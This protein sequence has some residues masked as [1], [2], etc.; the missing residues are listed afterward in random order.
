MNALGDLLTRYAQRYGD[1][2]AVSAG[3]D[4]A[5]S[6]AEL[7]PASRHAEAW[8]HEVVP[9]SP[10][11]LLP[12]NTPGDVALLLGALRS[13]LV[14]LVGDPAWSEHEIAE[15]L[16]RTGASSV[17]RAQ[18][19]ESVAASITL[20]DGGV[21]Y[22]ELAAE[23]G[24]PLRH[25]L[26]GIDF[27]RFTSGSSGAPRCLGFGIEAMINAASAWGAATQ[28]TSADTVMCLAALNNGLAFN[29]SLLAVFE[30]GATLVLPGVRPIPSSMLAALRTW[31]PTVLVA[32]PFVY[33]ALAERDLGGLT[34][35][36]LL[37]SSAAPLRPDTDRRWSAELGTHICNYYG[38]A[39]VGP[40]TFNDGRVAGSL[41]RA[42]AGVELLEIPT[43]E[44]ENGS[45]A[46]D[47]TP[48]RIAV[49]TAAMATRYLDPRPPDFA[50]HLDS[51]G[52][53]LTQD[54]GFLR[55]GDLFIT[56]RAD[57]IVNIAGRKIDPGEIADVLLRHHDVSG[58]LVR[59]EPT[60]T[61]PVLCAYVESATAG[62]SDLI[63][64][65]RKY[66]SQYKIPQRWTIVPALPRSSAGKIMSAQLAGIGGASQ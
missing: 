45:R 16:K 46:V 60:T 56:G 2:T 66:L 29:T 42:L 15:T 30:V 18:R 9:H 43:P 7:E 65:C 10:F 53:Y 41:G 12:G 36:R 62:R 35:L 64:H 38:L 31:S 25:D 13:G 34:S 59:A 51:N 50:D 1:R 27:G 5:Y 22:L 32:F 20:G 17:V 28:L 24:A 23:P 33:E 21:R 11:L 57:R 48:A 39:E 52:R 40:V 54:L 37:V 49:R 47:P 44:T 58:A 55:D 6:Y 63:D 61:E 8:L 14:P 3:A 4:A 26:D 19:P